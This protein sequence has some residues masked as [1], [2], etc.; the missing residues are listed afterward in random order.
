MTDYSILTRGF[1]FWH[2]AKPQL[3]SSLIPEADSVQEALRHLEAEFSNLPAVKQ[4]VPQCGPSQPQCDFP[5][6]VVLGL[7]LGSSKSGPE[8]RISVL[9]VYVGGEPKNHNERK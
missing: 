9:V 1:P 4:G 8:R 2:R 3:V 7:S 6:P 5:P